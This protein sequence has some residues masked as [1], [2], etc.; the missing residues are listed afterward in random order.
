[1]DKIL[2]AICLIAVFSGVIQCN[3]I[4]GKP[5]NHPPVVCKAGPT[6]CTD[7]E[8]DQWIEILKARRKLKG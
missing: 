6:A 8:Y 5:S 1:M 2:I 7:E 4:P 3:P